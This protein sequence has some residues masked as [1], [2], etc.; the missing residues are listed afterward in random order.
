MPSSTPRNRKLRVPQKAW[1]GRSTRLNERPRDEARP[2]SRFR[3]EDLSGSGHLKALYDQLV[4]AD[5]HPHSYK[6]GVGFRQWLRDRAEANLFFF[7]KWIFCQNPDHRQLF[8]LLHHQFAAFLTDYARTRRKLLM[9]PVVHLKTT[10]GSHALPLHVL[11]QKPATNIYFKG[12]W[13]CDQRILLGNENEIKAKEN[14]SVIASHLKENPWIRYLWPE[15]CPSDSKPYRWTDFAIQVPRYAILPEPSVTAIGAETG[16][17]GRHYTVVIL[18][19]L[20]GI[21]AGQSAQTMDRAK[22]TQAAVRTRLDDPWRSIEIEIGT[23]QSADDIYSVK[24]R[25]TTVEIMCRAIEEHSIPGDENSPLVPIWPEK[26]S[27]EGVAQLRAATDPILWALW[28]MNKPVPTGFTGLN[29]DDLRE[30]RFVT[31]G[32]A[33]FLVF[34]EVHHLDR[35]ILMRAQR[36]NLHPAMR[37][38]TQRP[39]TVTAFDMMRRQLSLGAGPDQVEHFRLKYSRCPEC[40]QVWERKSVILDGELTEVSSHDCPRGAQGANDDLLEEPI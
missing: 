27:S 18:D 2:K 25:D 36:K 28:Y 39:D 12:Q 29:W 38:L 8:G 37:L 23:H 30:F 19:D 4:A 9:C 21:R 33:E 24:K 3:T 7:T 17:M 20:A 35:G 10:F 22:R 1:S 6:D 15:L 34:E 31:R 5:E 13:G 26:Y 11:I 32:N 14:L 16:F 40:G